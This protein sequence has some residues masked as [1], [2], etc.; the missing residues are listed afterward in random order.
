MHYF[1]SADQCD[2]GFS[3][4]AGIQMARLVVRGVVVLAFVLL[5][6]L[7]IQLLIM[8]TPLEARTLATV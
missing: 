8:K 3:C 5:M 2:C 6:V 1:R 7:N 4:M